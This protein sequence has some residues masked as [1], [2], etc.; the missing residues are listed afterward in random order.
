MNTREEFIDKAQLT[1]RSVREQLN[2]KRIK[3]NWHESDVSVLEGVFA[4]GDRKVA[5]VIRK[6][7][8]KGC[9]YDSWGEHFHYDRWLEAFDECDVDLFFYTTRE[10]SL[11]EIF[12]WDF[13]D[14]GVTKEFLKCEW[15]RAQEGIVTPNCKMQCQGC[16]A[17]RFGGGICFEKRNESGVI[18]EVSAK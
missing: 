8:E 16:G 11:D 7:Y 10:R 12:P 4:R 18:E 17:A 6:A 15:L 13:L 9:L 5:D 3:Y 14:C 1:K 2:Q